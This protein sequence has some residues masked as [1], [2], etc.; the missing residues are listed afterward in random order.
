MSLIIWPRSNRRTCFFVH[1]LEFLQ[2]FLDDSVDDEIEKF[3]NSK[4]SASRCCLAF[5][6]FLANFSLVSLRWFYSRRKVSDIAFFCSCTCVKVLFTDTFVKCQFRWNI[7]IISI[8]PLRTN[9]A[10][11]LNQ[12]LLCIHV[13]KGVIITRL[14]S[15]SQYTQFFLWA[16]SL[17][18]TFRVQPSFTKEQ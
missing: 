16:T 1:F 18:T 6:W 3:S 8:F 17:Q 5:A 11:F 15:S 10:F 7:E 2:L 4:S 9:V 14:I 12:L 13:K